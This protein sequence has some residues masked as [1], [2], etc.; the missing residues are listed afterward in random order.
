MERKKILVLTDSPK[1]HTGFAIVGREIWTYLNRT[2]RY[3][4]KCVGWFHQE[5]LE[6][7]PYPILTTEKDVNGRITQEDKYGMK[8]LPGYVEK[9]KP[10]LVWTLGDMWMVDHVMQL[11]SRKSFK[12][13]GYF[14]I[15]GHPSPSKWGPVV[16]NMDVA[17]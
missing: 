11:P 1:L 12:W 2:G 8:S 13:I 7:I 5:T 4:I 10:D 17:D 14:P 9:F 15:D 6:D 16:E 3:D